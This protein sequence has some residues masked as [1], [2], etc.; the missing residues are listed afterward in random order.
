[1]SSNP[2]SITA[3]R[4]NVTEL[5]IALAASTQNATQSNPQSAHHGNTS[6][7]LGGIIGGIAGISLVIIAIV[8]FCRRRRRHDTSIQPVKVEHSNQSERLLYIDK[9]GFSSG[10]EK[11]QYQEVQDSTLRCIRA[12]TANFESQDQLP[13]VVGSSKNNLCESRPYSFVERSASLLYVG[14]AMAS[15]LDRT[16]QSSSFEKPYEADVS[17]TSA[18]PGEQ[19]SEIASRMSQEAPSEVQ[20]TVPAYSDLSSIQWETATHQER[21]QEVEQMHARIHSLESPQANHQ[22][23]Q[24]DYLKEIAVLRAYV[25]QLE[26]QIYGPSGATDSNVSPPQY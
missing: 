21:V 10:A 6:T 20:S 15:T 7:I 12:S 3:T 26:A 18:T 25:G 23:R 11:P 19:S 13:R 2:I 22:V 1:M 8:L 4:F 17:G 14:G 9:E 16:A 24:E 5:S